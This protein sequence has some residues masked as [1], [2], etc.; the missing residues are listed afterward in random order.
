M[1]FSKNFEHFLSVCSIRV[2]IIDAIIVADGIIVVANVTVVTIVVIG[3]TVAVT[4]V[5]VGVAAVDVVVVDVI[6]A[7]VVIVVIGLADVAIGVVIGSDYF[8]SSNYCPKQSKFGMFGHIISLQRKTLIY[9]Y[10]ISVIIP[11]RIQMF[12]ITHTQ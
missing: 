8:L 12:P 11:Q 10:F 3:V 6:V 1:L 5:V 7:I 2:S 9:Y 4:I